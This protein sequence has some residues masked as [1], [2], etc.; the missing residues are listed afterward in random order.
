MGLRVV[1]GARTWFREDDLG[2]AVVATEAL[3]SRMCH[4]PTSLAVCPAILA[5]PG[6]MQVRTS[7]L[8]ARSLRADGLHLE[9]KRAEVV[10]M[11]AA[12]AGV[13]AAMIL[14]AMFATGFARNV[15]RVA[16]AQKSLC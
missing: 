11:P 12:L 9:R 8:R 13:L 15:R 3:S 16:R 10:T 6:V 5:A 2:A 4:G 14:V 1:G 7:F